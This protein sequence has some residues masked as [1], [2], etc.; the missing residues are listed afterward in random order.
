MLMIA[1]AEQKPTIVEEQ[2]AEDNSIVDRKKLADIM[3]EK[4]GFS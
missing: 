1:K 3:S 2:P 4:E